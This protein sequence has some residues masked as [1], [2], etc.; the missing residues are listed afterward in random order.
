MMAENKV[1]KKFT[2]RKILKDV[3]MK[4]FDDVFKNEPTITR[5]RFARVVFGV[6]SFPFLLNGTVRKHTEKYDYDTEFVE[7]VLRSFFVDDFTGG[8]KDLLKAF[9]LFQKLKLRFLEG[10]FHLRKWRTNDLNC[11]N[12]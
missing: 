10:L 3:T 8:E 11:V 7:R 9:T 2:Q 5:N 4:L 12:L 1:T 6:T